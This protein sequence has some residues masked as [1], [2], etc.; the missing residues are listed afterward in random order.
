MKK[1]NLIISAI[2]AFSLTSCS[3][4]ITNNDL[5]NISSKENKL[6]IG[7]SKLELENTFEEVKGFIISKDELK[8][9]TT[10]NSEF[11]TKAAIT[12]DPFLIYTPT[13]STTSYTLS[14]TFMSKLKSLT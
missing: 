8:L 7:N 9:S 10:E 11:N 1:I 13:G 14:L 6:T 3:S 12:P 5:S 2:F 4:N